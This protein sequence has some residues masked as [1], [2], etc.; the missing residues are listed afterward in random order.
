M[1]RYICFTYVLEAEIILSIEL[2]VERERGKQ[3][4]K[5]QLPGFR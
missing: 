3:R 2:H 5:G 1:E 4:T